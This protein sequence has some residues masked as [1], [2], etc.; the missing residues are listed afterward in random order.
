MLFYLIARSFLFV[1]YFLVPTTEPASLVP[2]I[3]LVGPTASGKTAV[4]VAL[5]ARMRLEV[6]S[7]DSL[8]VYRHMD[9][10]TA[11]PTVQERQRVIFHGLD[12]VDPDQEWTL[13]DFQS[14]GEAALCEIAEKEALALIVGGTGLYIRALT[15]RLAIPHVPPNEQA[16]AEWR[17]LAQAQGNT[18]LQAA[19]K[20]IDPL[21]AERIHGNDVFRMVRALE[22]Y[23]ATGIPLSEWHRRNQA[24]GMERNALLFGLRY[25]DRS[26]LY[27]RIN[28]RVEQMISQGFVD[29]VQ[30]LLDSGY[31]RQN[32]PLHSLGYCQLINFLA[33]QYSLEEAVEEI[34]KETRRFAK[35]QLTWF[36]ADSRIRWLEVEG[37][38]IEQLAEEIWVQLKE[39]DLYYD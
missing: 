18:A 23:T 3:A 36:H 5:A 26:L 28:S 34:K 6:I 13:A 24:A 9:I 14:L 8:Q 4:A 29:E 25:Q 27:D 37:K 21:A 19:L 22:V 2:R 1:L 30:H 10:G 7:A 31:G 15:T 17:R 35:R 20:V 16:R 33:G 32:K 39:N 38:T 12:V 11:K